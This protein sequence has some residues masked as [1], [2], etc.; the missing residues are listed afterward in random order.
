M[1]MNAA[2]QIRNPKS[3]DKPA[4]YLSLSVYDHDAEIPWECTIQDENGEFLTC[5]EERP[6]YLEEYE[7]IMRK[8]RERALGADYVLGTAQAADKAIGRRER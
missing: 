4:Y 3:S 8:R 6:G 1:P 2:H 7:R 5:S